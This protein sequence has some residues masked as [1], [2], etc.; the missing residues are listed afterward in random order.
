MRDDTE[1]RLM[2]LETVVGELV[3]SFAPRGFRECMVGSMDRCVGKL[4]DMSADE[5][6]DFA[7]FRRHVHE[8]LYGRSDGG[9]P[10]S[11]STSP[12]WMAPVMKAVGKTARR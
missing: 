5:R 1:L 2:A 10:S 12:A 6:E 8:I 3:R 11:E 7:V 9:Q 4:D